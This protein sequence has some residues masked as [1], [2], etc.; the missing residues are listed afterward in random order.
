MITT[1]QLFVRHLTAA[2]YSSFRA[3]ESDAEVKKFS[4]GALPVP[5]DAFARL[6]AD[7]SDAC[8]AVCT[9]DDHR[10]VGRC[11]FRPIEDRI[12][13]E[14]FLARTEQ[15]HRLGSELLEAMISYCATKYPHAKVAATTSPANGPA[16]RLLERH[17]FAD[18]GETVPTKAGFQSLY[19]Q[20]S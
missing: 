1:P 18:T 8:L 17:H 16:R 20:S 10:F 5:E 14:I 6:I 19:V 7:T 13:V 15:G 9:Q 12:E 4:G 2:D 11:G 3:L